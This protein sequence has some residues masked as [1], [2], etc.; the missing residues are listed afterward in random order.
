MK[1]GAD[2]PEIRTAY[3]RLVKE[4]HPDRFTDPVQ[5]KEA[6]EKL[7]QLNLAYEEALKQSE[8]KT[9]GFN[10]LPLQEAKHFAKRLL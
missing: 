8:R 10:Q 4:C 7:I 9:I 2:I 5:Q 1:Y 3:R 6:Q